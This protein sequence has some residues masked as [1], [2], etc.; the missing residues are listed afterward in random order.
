MGNVTDHLMGLHGPVIYAIVAALVFGE[1]ALFFGFVL[2][3]ETA[4]VAGG[5]LAAANRV[6]LPLLLAIVVVSA[7]V[8]D[9]VGYEIGRR[10][11]PRLLQTRAMRRYEKGVGKAQ[12]LIVRRGPLAVFIGRFTALLRALMPALVGTS[13]MPYP[14]FLL[15]NALG[16][17]VWG[18]GYTLGGYYAG[19][20][21]EH[22][23]NLIGRY[24]AIG[25]AAVVVLAL[26]IWG[27]RRHRREHAAGE[28]AEDSSSE[29]VRA[30]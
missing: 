5:V 18:I 23:A 20:T 14:R 3:G 29:G 26:V 11:G 25:V 17:I 13:K 9:S 2:P 10:F 24:A 22:T 12:A 21:F 7:V 27:V 15:F 8:G 28:A 30:S 6:S 1:A 4:I 19:K 16:G